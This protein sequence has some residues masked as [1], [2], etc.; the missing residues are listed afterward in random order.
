[1]NY[2]ECYTVFVFSQYPRAAKCYRVLAAASRQLPHPTNSAEHDIGP[3]FSDICREIILSVCHAIQY[4]K[5][6]CNTMQYNTI[7]DL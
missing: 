6:Q 3:S 5:I 1:M 7:N 4:N 2:N